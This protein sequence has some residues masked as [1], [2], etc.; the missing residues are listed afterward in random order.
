MQVESCGLFVDHSKPWLA[1]SSDGIVTD[2]SELHNTKGIL[3]VK[4]PYV[5]ERQ[6]I[7]N[8][9]KTVNGFCLSESK[10]QVMLSKSHAYY[11]QVQTQMHVTNLQ[12]CDFFVWSPMGDPSFRELNMNQPLWT[13]YSSKHEISISTSFYQLQCHI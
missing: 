13:K 7:E 5:C 9:C 11:F 6:T 10:G 1:A 3:E 12:W 8:A 4:C 2:L